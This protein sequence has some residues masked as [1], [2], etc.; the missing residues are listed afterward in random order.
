[1]SFKN[2]DSTDCAQAE[3]LRHC[4]AVIL[5]NHATELVSSH[6]IT[7]REK[8]LAM[9]SPFIFAS[10]DH[11]VSPAKFYMIPK[12]QKTPMVGRPIAASYLYIARL[13]SI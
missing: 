4:R 13:I 10:F 7:S 6:H 1:M 5:Q 12:I 3:T 9:Y 8:L 2:T 11:F